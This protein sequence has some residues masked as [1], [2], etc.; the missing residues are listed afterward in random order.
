MLS[1]P[2][3]NHSREFGNL[4]SS[5]PPVR[6]GEGSALTL[7]TPFPVDQLDPV[8]PEDCSKIDDVI[9]RV[10]ILGFD[11][12]PASCFSDFFQTASCKSPTFEDVVRETWKLF[13]NGVFTDR[14]SAVSPGFYSEFRRDSHGSDDLV[15]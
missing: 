7:L 3:A 15:S 11:G 2:P 5:W 14:Q 8:D 9:E 12:A 1:Y 13:A 4:P 10:V 6:L